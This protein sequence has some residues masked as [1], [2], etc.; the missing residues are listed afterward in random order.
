MAGSAATWSQECGWVGWSYVHLDWD[1]PLPSSVLPACTCGVKIPLAFLACVHRHPLSPACP[2]G[3]AV[4]W[5]GYCP[6]SQLRLGRRGQGTMRRDR[7][8]W[9]GEGKGLA[10]PC[11]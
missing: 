7:G 3:R 1:F 10:H 6:L 11:R 8:L 2:Q 5:D 4:L 9:V